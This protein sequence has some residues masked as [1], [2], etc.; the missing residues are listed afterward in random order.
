MASRG[1]D[2]ARR[3]LRILLTLAPKQN[4]RVAHGKPTPQRLL[5]MCG[6]INPNTTMTEEIRDAEHIGLHRW[7]SNF[8]EGLLEILAVKQAQ[9]LCRT[10]A[11]KTLVV[12]IR[13]KIRITFI[14]AWTEAGG[15][16]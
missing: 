15:R 7:K 12:P 2:K 3:H 10:L 8:Q 4:K 16:G 1:I 5:H 9:L 11:I 6:R 13:M 14:N